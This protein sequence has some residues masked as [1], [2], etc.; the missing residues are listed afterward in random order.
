MTDEIRDEESNEEEVINDDS[1]EEVPAFSQSEQQEILSSV[2][3][4]PDSKNDEENIEKENSTNN[5]DVE[6]VTVDTTKTGN[7]SQDDDVD[8]ETLE[9]Y[10]EFNSFI[11]SKT[12]IEE[13][14]GVKIVIPTGIDVVDAIL[15]GGFAVGCL[16][17]IVGQPGGGKC[18]DYDEEVEIYID[19]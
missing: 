6:H 1:N 16:N 2:S 3:I 18:L 7:L 5:S 11:K 14:S 12:D 17:I 8:D 15:G 10:N 4:E 9:L 19:E 13:S